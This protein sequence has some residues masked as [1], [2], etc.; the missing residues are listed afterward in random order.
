MIE[1]RKRKATGFKDYGRRSVTRNVAIGCLHCCLYCCARLY[2]L[3]FH[4]RTCRT[5]RDWGCERIV[6]VLPKIHRWRAPV[7]FPSR[8]DLT[9]RIL[10]TAVKWLR[11][12][13]RARN[14]VIVVSKPRL[15]T[16]ARFCAQLAEF[17]PQILFR[18]S[19]TSLDSDLSRLWEPFAP[20]PHERLLCLRWA[21]ERG[22]R[23]S[24]SC[25]PMLGGVEGALAVY[26]AVMPY[27]TDTCWFGPAT[28][29]RQCVFERKTCPEVEAA[30]QR[31]EMLQAEGELLRLYDALRGDPKVRRKS[32]IRR[33][34]RVRRRRELRALRLAASA[35]R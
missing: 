30:C 15:S 8:H 7:I 26:G 3:I 10:P 25:E 29:L 13:L 11:R 23:T 19:I 34:V 27:V 9:P 17:K 5:W 6:G 32:P 22:W 2:G 14:K 1:K 20:P 24:V 28:N 16:L 35:P 31:L 4:S 33:L 12:C 21:Y 18:F